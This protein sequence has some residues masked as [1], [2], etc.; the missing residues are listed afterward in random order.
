MRMI[1]SSEILFHYTADVP[2]AA[3]TAAL[4]SLV[5]VPATMRDGNN[6]AIK[7]AFCMRKRT[8]SLVSTFVLLLILWLIWTRLH[9]VFLVVMPWWG[10]LLMAI[11]LFLT[12]DH[13]VHRALRH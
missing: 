6:L 9:I 4:L 8:S 12:I 7:G 1:R 5:V 10:F 2:T 11:V 3:V 13:L